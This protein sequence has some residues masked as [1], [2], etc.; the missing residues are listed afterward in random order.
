MTTTY[1]KNSKEL[2][3]IFEEIYLE[4]RYSEKNRNRRKREER[5]SKKRAKYKKA[6]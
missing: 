4:N 6:F 1:A 3:K 2:N 5:L